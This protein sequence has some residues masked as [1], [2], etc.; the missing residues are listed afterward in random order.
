[1]FTPKLSQSVIN[2]INTE[3][4]KIPDLIKSRINSYIID[5]DINYV[6][7]YISNYQFDILN[8]QSLLSDLRFCDNITNN[9]VSYLINI[10]INNLFAR[11]NRNYVKDCFICREY[12]IYTCTTLLKCCNKS[13]C[14]TCIQEFYK[15]DCPYCRANIKPFIRDIDIFLIQQNIDNQDILNSPIDINNPIFNDIKNNINTDIDNIRS[16]FI[17]IYKDQYGDDFEPYL[18]SSDDDINIRHWYSINLKDDINMTDKYEYDF[19]NIDVHNNTLNELQYLSNIIEYV[20]LHVDIEGYI[21]DHIVEGNINI[22][23]INS[24]LIKSYIDEYIDELFEEEF[25]KL[26]EQSLPKTYQI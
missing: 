20:D 15:F 10:K 8:Y 16:D 4:N 23:N 12:H 9:I 6:K 1:M 18:L 11:I 24:D 21:N 13:C 25:I 5:D 26:Y 14:T 7:S 3:Y 19:D 2:I 22:D 17:R